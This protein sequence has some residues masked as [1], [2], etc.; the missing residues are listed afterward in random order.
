[1]LTLPNGNSIDLDMLKTAME[2]SDLAHR[3]FLNLAT[4][5]VVFFSD[6]LGT[7]DEDERLLEEID[8]STD[9][10]AIERIPSHVAYQ[11]K[12][13][14]VDEL[15]GPADDRAAEKLSLA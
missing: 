8:G 10:I 11:W 14:F 1:M 5:E 9:H 4:G 3:Y 6:Y 13:D 2:D 7:S 12:V 15:V